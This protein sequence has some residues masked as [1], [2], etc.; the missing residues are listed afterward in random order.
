MYEQFNLSAKNP[1]ISNHKVYGQELLPGL[2]Y[3]DLIYQAYK[4]NHYSFDRLEL[5]NLSIFKPIATVPGCSVR[6]GVHCNETSAG[7]WKIRLEGRNQRDGILEP[8]TTL[9]ATAEMSLIEPVSYDETLDVSSVKRSAIRELGIYDLYEEY[10]SQELVHTGFMKAEGQVYELEAAVILDLSIGP[11]AQSSSQEFLFHPALI[12]GSGVGAGRM[13]A[14]ATE[15]EQRLFLPLSY[16]AFHASEPL[17]QRCI[18]R[19]QKSSVIHKNELMFWTMEFFNR[20]GKKVGELRNFAGKLVREAGLINPERKLS[21]PS[22]PWQE[23]ISGAPATS[24][25]I[26]LDT[27]AAGDAAPVISIERFLRQLM[28]DVLNSSAE[29]IHPESGYYEMGLD[30]PGLL[31]IVRSIESRIKTSLSPTLLFEY[32][33]IAEL[34]AY[35][36][37]H[38]ASQFKQIEAASEQSVSR[39]PSHPGF[40]DLPKPLAP[41]AL[42][43]TPKERTAADDDIAI[44]GMSGRYPQARNLQEFWTNLQEGKDCISEIPE[45]RWD[46]KRLAGIK[47]PGGKEMSKWGGFIEDPDCFDPKFFRI[48]PREAETMDPQERLFLETCW[49]AIEDAG[50]TPKSLVTPRGTNKRRNVGVFAGVMHKDYSLVGAEALSQGEAFPLSLNAGP[51]ANRVSYFCNFHGPSMTVDTLCSSSLTAVHLAME[52]IKRGESEVALAGGVNLSLHPAKYMT[53]GMWGM[54][55]SDGYCHTFGEGGDGYVSAEGVASVLLK[56]L[57][58]AIE[59]NDRIYATIKG[60]AI[61]HVGTVS[62]IMVPGPVAQGEAI[63]DCLKQSGINPRTIRYVEAHGTGTSLGD[64]IEIEGLMKAFG[65]YTQDRQFCSI[66]SVKSNIGHAESAAGVIGLQKAALQIYHKTLVPSLHAEELNPYIDFEQSPFYVQRVT[67]EWQPSVMMEDGRQVRYPRRAALSSFGATGSNAHVILEEYID[68]QIRGVAR[69]KREQDR[70]VLVPLSAKNNER[71]KSYAVELLKHLQ[72]LPI[73]EKVLDI[74]HTESQLAGFLEERIRGILAAII[75]VDGELIEASVPWSEYG[76]EP[77]H[78]RQL[79]DKILEEFAVEMDDREWVQSCTIASVAAH[80]LDEHPERLRAQSEVAAHDEKIAQEEWD[81]QQDHNVTSIEDVAFTLQVGREAMEVRVAFVVREISELIEGLQAFLQNK[82]VLEHGYKGTIKPD[83]DTVSLSSAREANE[84]SLSQWIHEG[85]MEHL[86]EW[87]VKGIEIDWNLLYGDNNRA[88]RISLPTYPFARE[89]YWIPVTGKSIAPAAEVGIHPLLHKNTSDFMEQRFSSRFTGHE[90]FLSDHVVKKEK[91][92]PGV[93]YLEMARMA[94]MQSLGKLPNDQTAIRLKNVVWIRPI[95][96]EG[97]PAIVNIRLLPEEHGGIGYEIY[98]TPQGVTG[99][100][101]TVHSKGHAELVRPGTQV[102]LKYDE[103]KKQFGE[104]SIPA[105]RFYEVFNAMGMDYGP[106][107][108]GIEEAYKEEGSGQI[109]A[110]LSIPSIVTS[111]LNEY[112]LHPSLMDSALQATIGF[113]MSSEGEG[114][115]PDSVKPVMPFALQEL[116]ILGDCTPNMWAWIRS[117]DQHAAATIGKTQ[118]LDIDL[119]DEEGRIRVRMRGFSTRVLE[120]EP[121]SSSQSNAI[122]QESHAQPPVG[123]IHLVPVWDAVLP[124]K[125]ERLP[126]ALARVLVVG[127]KENRSTFQQIYPQMQFIDITSQDTITGIAAQIEARG[128]IDHVIWMAPSEHSLESTAGDEWIA[129]QESGVK[130]LFRTIKSLI[131]LGYSTRSLEWTVITFNTQSVHGSDTINPAHASIHGLVGSMAKEYPNWNIRIVDL[132]AGCDWPVTDLLALPADRRGHPWAYRNQEWYRQHLVPMNPPPM[133]ESS[134]KVGGVYVVIGG[135]GGIGKAWSEYMVRT[136][137]ANVVWIGRRPIDDQIQSDLDRISQFGPKPVYIAAD[138]THL[139]EL[140]GAYTAIKAEFPGINGI[141]H[142]AMVLSDCSLADMVEEQ[143]QAGLSAKIDVSVRMAQVFREEPLDFVLFFSSLIALIKNPRQSSYASGCTFKDAFA[144]R[145]ASEWPCKVK[146]MNWG[147]WSSADAAASGDV[148]Q[149]SRI[150][151]G[152]ITPEDGMKAVELLVS[153]PIHQMAMITTTKPLLVEGMN[154]KERFDIRSDNVPPTIHSFNLKG[155]IAAA[156]YQAP[157]LNEG[158]GLNK[159]MI[160]LLSRML[161]S[162]LTAMGLL[163]SGIKA[164]SD[165]NARRGLAPMYERWLEESHRVLVQ[166]QFLYQDGETYQTMK[167]VTVDRDSMWKEWELRKKE[168][169]AD[170]SLKAWMT[171]TEAVLRALPDILTGQR[172]ATDILFPNSSMSMVEGIYKNNPVADYFNEALADALIAYVEDRIKADPSAKLRLI[173]IGA[174]TGGTSSMLFHKLKPYRDHIEEYCYTDISKAFLLFAEKEYGPEHAYLTYRIFNVDAPASGPNAPAGAF[175]IAIATNVLH[176]TRNIR[177]TL[178]NAKAVLK[179]NGIILINELSDNRLFTH[180]TFGLLEGWWLYED[181]AIRIPGSPGLYPATWKA[182]LESEGYEGVFFPAQ[183]AHDWGQQIIAAGSNGV[184]RQKIAL[185]DA[186]PHAEVRSMSKLNRIDTT[187]TLQPTIIAEKRHEKNIAAAQT[188][189]AVTEQMLEDHVK[190]TI[191]EKLSEALK[192]NRNEIEL[193]DSFADY[194]LDSII[195]VHL[196]Q[197]LNQALNIELDT[198]SLFDYSSVKQLT[199]YILSDHRDAVAS[200]FGQNLKDEAVVVEAKPGESDIEDASAPRSYFGR[201]MDAAPLPDSQMANLEQQGVALKTSMQKEPIAIIGMSGKYA[202]SAN[203]DEL[204]THLSNGAELIGES[205]RWDLSTYYPEDAEYCDRGGFVENIDQFDPSFFNING[206]EANY[207]DPQQRLF[208]EECWKA[209]EDSGY[210]GSRIQGRQCGVYVGCLGGAGDYHQLSGDDAPAQAFWGIAGSVI[211][212]RIAYYLDLKGP[213]IAIDTACSSSLVAVHI[214][215]QGLWAGETEMAL[216]GGVFI[217]STPWYYLS[218]NKAGMLSATGH[219]YT[220]DDRADGFV[221][222]EGAGVLVLK[223]LSEAMDDGDHIYGVIRGSGMNQD[224]TTNGITAPSAISQ[225][226][227]ERSV[228]DAFHIDPSGIQVVEA[229]GT[230]TKLGDPIEYQALTR[231]FRK[232]TDN[233]EYCAIGSI[234]TN[235]GHAA[236]AAGVAGI[237]KIL[238]SMKHQQIPPT[239]NFKSGNSNIQFKDSPFYVN[240]TLRDWETGSNDRRRAAVSSFGFSGT[241]AHIVIEEASEPAGS[242]SVKPGYLLALSARTPEQLRQQADQLI[243]YCERNQQ[244]DCGNLSYTLLAGRKHFNHRLACVV[245]SVDELI[246]YLSKWLARSKVPQVYVSERNENDRR[247]QP[248]LKRY[249]NQCIEE[250]FAADPNGYVERLSTIAELYVQ[251]Y[252]LNYEALFSGERYRI[253]SL[254]TYPFATERYWVPDKKNKRLSSHDTALPGQAMLHPLLHRNTSDL[255]GVRYSTTFKGSEPYLAYGNVNGTKTI[256][257]LTYLEMARKAAEMSAGAFIGPHEGIQIKD[258]VWSSPVELGMEG[259]EIHI[260]VFPDDEGISFEIYSSSGLSSPEPVI[261][262]QGSVS[263]YPVPG[264]ETIDLNL[265]REQCNVKYFSKEDWYKAYDQAEAVYSPEHRVVDELFVGQNEVLAKLS[266]HATWT[267]SSHPFIL[268]P[269]ITDAALQA[270]IGLLAD[271]DPRMSSDVIQSMLPLYLQEMQM[272]GEPTPQVWIHVRKSEHRVQGNKDIQVDM[273]LYDQHG[274]VYAR[275]KGLTVRF[276]ESKDKYTVGH[277]MVG[278][279]LKL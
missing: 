18:T 218:T 139:E 94:L 213:A 204:W 109:L 233:K 102:V 207:M 20:D 64:P 253:L 85:R 116:D 220:F 34:S 66:G 186:S 81:R 166:N 70:P 202:Q 221:P 234:K 36:E 44:I 15:Q 155:D 171:L 256:P 100:E 236:H 262:N 222:G 142:S 89:R 278:G 170:P 57:N 130:P 162:E 257:G 54:H 135:A 197:V 146:V 180:L 169:L 251:G 178:R 4:K 235:I 24:D 9:Y 182:V 32:T 40:H 47:S 86:A 173:E 140:R 61:N 255:S 125:G 206:L 193:E 55:S 195:G 258:M 88:S 31:G 209:L 215:C 132:E 17:R 113:L 151:L 210:A 194:G 154:P 26:T 49:E 143:F 161:L 16:A 156:G 230:G 67:E 271:R 75:H 97:T 152:L 3:I 153:N 96:V 7:S 123:N 225:E 198:T 199:A 46:R 33:T 25:K 227:L 45:S 183:E 172:L 219:S 127:R 208:M 217:Q 28:A 179:K 13:F 134:F 250:C 276:T 110:K 122:R 91:I 175:D 190:E 223:R 52:S 71:L 117:S 240:T 69:T 35:L 42:G 129:G 105:S 229:H 254:P 12:D 176:A 159:E 37:E 14:P 95:S 226:S 249:G 39:S 62:G 160:D 80:L 269:C 272:I 150:G 104:Q 201:F 38:Y 30:S 279:G 56:P 83:K 138:A 228:Y 145:L 48:S 21:S 263:S 261:H 147:Y 185:Q 270:A 84:E 165:G 181:A 74:E 1:I 63:A 65:S 189:R 265:I 252:A 137:K 120:G 149:L 23:P 112:V 133:V 192:V 243:E 241:N 259:L 128:L 264:A 72:G 232:Y 111:T 93:A 268:H 60:S 76:V 22:S 231:A 158:Q 205:P 200:E 92:L 266:L 108:R 141:V 68:T 53:Y 191:I 114:R 168:W 27:G 163:K 214:A 73:R 246:S 260:D 144:H 107:H 131:R 164:A 79:K 267:D 11:D 8:E 273:D 2:A 275:L 247:E 224:G 119:C 118:K 87:W 167:S 101:F 174:G 10:Q 245:R 90:F 6:L 19:V 157:R 216:A 59:D 5:R 184:V 103:L 203:V 187:T 277:D 237:I 98:S 78:I 136:Y 238:L 29:D 242:H 99:T 211:P 177:H 239:L 58:K 244:A 124:D 148:Q 121:Q 196:V 126:Q 43:S 106:A 274:K 41:T 50:Y 51:I 248:S 212:A 82:D 77:V 188:T 115:I